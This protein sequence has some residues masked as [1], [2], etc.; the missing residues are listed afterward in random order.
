MNITETQKEQYGLYNT[1]EEM[2][3][4]TSSNPTDQ[5]G[6][7]SMQWIAHY[8]PTLYEYTLKCNSVV[9][10]GVNQVCSTW[11][12]LKAKPEGGVLSIDIDLER[13]AYMQKIGLDKNIWL[14]WAKH[15]STQEQVAFNA[16]EC[17]SLDVELPDHDLLFID[18]D[19]TYNQLSQ[20]L[21]LHGNKAQKY[22][23]MHDTTL[24]PELNRAIN[25]FRE[26]NTHFVVEKVFD[27]NPGLTI[28]KNTL[29]N[30]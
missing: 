21:K 19:H 6:K 7:N 22:I 28:L 18:S 10:I 14:H 1:I 30:E 5:K 9:E 13:S 16:Q 17:S 11:A 20:E 29:N 24:F 8:M 26:V 3:N 23:I 4:F 2:Y 27:N 25:E 12:F 15:L